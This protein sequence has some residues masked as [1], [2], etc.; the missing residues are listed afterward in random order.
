M[1]SEY[2]NRQEYATLAMSLA[3]AYT[4]ICLMG[5]DRSHE[6][7]HI[8]WRDHKLQRLKAGNSKLETLIRNVY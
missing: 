2:E 3:P 6:S 1:E 4:D 5:K 7:Q 8:D